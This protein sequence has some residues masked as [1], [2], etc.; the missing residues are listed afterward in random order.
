[1]LFADSFSPLE[2]KACPVGIHSLPLEGPRLAMDTYDTPRRG[3]GSEPGSQQHPHRGTNDIR[4]SRFHKYSMLP[5]V[6]SSNASYPE[7]HRSKGTA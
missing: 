2:R 5:N 3:N 4:H 7:A 1:M 6:L